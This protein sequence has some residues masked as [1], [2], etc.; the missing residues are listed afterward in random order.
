MAGDNPY[1]PPASDVSVNEPALL[2][3]RWSRLG[4]ALIDGVISMLF[5]FPTMFF[6]GMWEKSIAGEQTLTDNLLLAAI[7]CVA[8]VVVNGYLLAT[9]GQTIGK[10]VVGTRIVS[11]NDEKIL[12]LG[13]VIGLRYVPIWGA[14]QVPL[15]GPFV[16]LVNVLFIFRADK[17][18]IHDLIAGT[19]VINA[20]A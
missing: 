14:S 16:G 6:T 20:T 15:V 2:A 10:R 12:S 3:S 4:G 18:C 17:R 11:V 9:S 19:K 13:K 1:A 8:F 7:G 5:I